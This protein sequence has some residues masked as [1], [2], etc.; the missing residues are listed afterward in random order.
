[1]NNEAYKIIH[2]A[3]DHSD[4]EFFSIGPKGVILKRITFKFSKIENVVIMAFG[5]VN[6][7]GEID[8]L[9]ISNNGDRNKVLATICQ[10]IARYLKHYPER[11]VYFK[12][13]TEERTRLY[14]MII[15]NNIKE[16]EAGHHIWMEL[17]YKFVP[18]QPSIKVFG[19]AI[20]RK[21]A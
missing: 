4:Y 8:D 9:S 12:G 5:D 13:S 10:T 18:F 7:D 14:R 1:M 3:S 6:Q 19:F 20:K 16:F 2:F 15:N 11:M 17:D 21:N